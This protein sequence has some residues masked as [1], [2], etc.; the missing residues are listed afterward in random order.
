VVARHAFDLE[1]LAYDQWL[2]RPDSY[3]VVAA[4]VMPNQPSVVPVM[5]RASELLK[6]QTGSGSI[7]GYQAGPDRV[8]Q[9][10]GA[11]YDALAELNLGY[12][13]P[14]A[15]ISGFAQKIRTPGR[16]LEELQGTCIDLSVTYASCLWQAGLDP[17]ILLPPGHAMPGYFRDQRPLEGLAG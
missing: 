14:P 5:R 16:V 7:E 15:G 1:V 8:N 4:F 12:V 17:V 2:I 11:V 13:D 9:I 3:D 10:A 6:A